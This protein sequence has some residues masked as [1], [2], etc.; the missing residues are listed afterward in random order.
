M[1]HLVLQ[2]A[3]FELV[4]LDGDLVSLQIQT[5]QVDR[6]G[7]GQLEGQPRDRKTTFVVD[8]LSVGLDDPWVDD[9][10][11]S[12]TDV[13][14]EEPFGDAHLI[15]GQAH[16]RLVVHGLE[17]VVGEL[18]DA[19]VD[20]GDLFGASG[21]HRVADLAD[22]VASHGAHVTGTSPGL[23]VR[24]APRVS[25]PQWQ[26]MDSETWQELRS[27]AVVYEDAGVVVLD[28][29]A[30]ISVTGERHGTDLVRLAAHAGERLMPA[31]RIDK[32]TSG[33]IV[34]AKSLEAHGSLARQFNRRSVTKSYVAITAP[35]GMP[36]QGTIDLPLGVGRKGR[37]RIAARRDAIVHDEDRSRW[38]VDAADVREGRSYPSETRFTRLHDDGEHALL[39]VEPVS[40]RRHQIRV[41][42]AWIGHAIVGDPL[43]AKAPV[44]R[45]CLHAAR[46]AFDAP[47]HDDTRL[48]FACP[49]PEDFWYPLGG[50]PT[51][52][53]Y[54]DTAGSSAI[55]ATR[56]WCG[57]ADD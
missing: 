31:H 22:R 49:P 40:G 51:L 26:R 55:P 37:V 46:L 50:R 56:S 4:G 18:R 34:F 35:G 33:L 36:E 45:A 7:T 25:G 21:E 54:P 38:S 43:F 10:D 27:R 52:D 12:M 48:S 29:P 42:L 41:H 47:W 2:G 30:G 24:T 3:P 53:A 15:G 11:R 5:D 13:V 28:K 1:I 23:N 14:D 32:V 6:I 17:H 57:D 44:G 8:E 20:V 9:G 16:A 39:I 19:A